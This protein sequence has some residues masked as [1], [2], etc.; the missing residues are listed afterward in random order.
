MS[1]NSKLTAQQQALVDQ[2]LKNLEEG[3]GLWKQGWVVTG[4]PQSA[5]TGKRY[6]GL[7]NFFLT[8]AAMREGYKDN[9]WATFHQIQEN[10]WS[11][12]TDEEGKS[13]AKGK[14]ETVEFYKLRDKATKKPF[15]R[16]VL[17]GLTKE[18]RDDYMKENVYPL[19]KY[20][21]VFNADIIDGIPA[22]EQTNEIDE[23][24]RSERAEQFID[25]WSKT[26]SEISYGGGS[27]Y[28]NP[29]TDKIRLP[30]RRDF[31]TAEDY[32]STAF[33]EIGHSTGHEKRLNR[34]LE[35]GFGSSEY[36][37]EELRAEIAS[38][39]IEQEF[40]IEVDESAVRNNSAYLQA[41]KEEI[42]EDPNALFKAIIDADRSAK[43]LVE[44][45]KS[46][47]K[48]VQKYA[49]RESENAVG[50][51]IFRVYMQDESGAIV[52]AMAAAYDTRE[53]L[54][55]SF[56]EFQED[57]L[58]KDAEFQEVS[59]EELSQTK[60]DAGENEKQEEEAEMIP[61]P[62]QEY[63]RPSELVAR[64]VPAAVAVNMAD[65]GI[66]SLTRMSD[67]EVV[68]K[69]K[70]VRGGDTFSKLY[71]GE[72]VFES[73]TKDERILM[74]RLGMF[75]NGDTEQLIRVFK[76]SG[77]FRDIKPTSY[78]MQLAERTMTTLNGKFN[79]LP[80][81]TPVDMGKGKFGMNAKI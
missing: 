35:G 25:F 16:S 79:P 67:R 26:E 62:S 30:E 28:Y 36:A 9:R 5:T 33:H 48:R 52:M 59:Y 55:E 46:K 38:M 58:W 66:D 39:F 29:K 18:E 71:N 2:V 70:N 4:A 40:G 60:S 72:R 11:F 61:A 19:R 8:L 31:H 17:D 23:R 51:T 50:D 14:S 53:Q 32:Y 78:Y 27:A 47:N 68:E 24:T 57:P 63:I 76:S 80:P 34:N 12:K 22:P 37:K 13:I 45:E 65:R 7:N 41:W 42:K 6:R 49:I 74:M 73:E 21:K 10:G 81:K 75:C 64:S 43:Y 20:Y 56:K 15:D 1:E 3:A 77:Q 69:A 54:M 44:K